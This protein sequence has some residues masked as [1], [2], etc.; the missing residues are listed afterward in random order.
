MYGRS[1]R[2]S[3]SETAPALGLGGLVEQLV[4]DAVVGDVD[5]GRVGAEHPDQL[6]PGRLGRHDQPGGAAGRG[7]DRGLVERGRD[8]VVRVGVGEERQVVDGHHGRG[9]G[10]QR[11]R[12][13]RR[14]D[15]LGSDLLGHQ[16]QAAL[17]P[18]QPGGPVRDRGGRG[19]HAGAGHEAAVAFL[20]GPLADEG[21]IG[22]RRLQ[23]ADQSVDVAP[24]GA[25]VSGHCG[26]VDKHTRRHGQSFPFRE[27]VLSGRG[28]LRP[29]PWRRM[30]RQ[31][32]A[33]ALAGNNAASRRRR[34]GRGG[35]PRGSVHP[36]A[37]AELPGLTGARL[38]RC[39]G[40][41][42]RR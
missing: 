40:L 14:V 26:R 35:G 39:P 1:C 31:D 36:G 21:Q 2:P 42:L 3:R 27:Q 4:V 7:A 18:G 19:D 9:A 22:S 8:R 6:V 37:I 16:R 23:G 25:A 34:T 20:V 17:L 10:P 13:V 5:A 32:R 29:P 33:Y 12:V 38:R 30:P 41:G 28:G 11:H 15:H 24:D